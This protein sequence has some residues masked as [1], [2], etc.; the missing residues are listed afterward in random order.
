MS[1]ARHIP[2]LD[3]LRGVAVAGVML[4]HFIGGIQPQT[5]IERGVAKVA[6][7]GVWGVDLFFVLSGFLITGILFDAKG[8]KGYF[9]N[10]YARRTL[11]IFPLYYAILLLLFV[12]LPTSLL[13]R[14]DPALLGA[15]EA[16]AWVWPYLTNVYIA[17]EGSFALPYLSHFWSLAVEEHF[18]LVWPFVVA[19][20][21][22]GAAMR[23][24]VILGLG[25]TCLRIALSASGVNETSI[26]VLTPCRLD[27][28][29]AGAYLALAT[30]SPMG[31]TIGHRASTLM[32]LSGALT[33]ACSAWHAVLG[34]AD[35]FVLPL[36]SLAMALFFGFL[37]FAVCEEHGPALLKRL[38]RAQWLRTLGKYSYGLYVFHGLIAYWMHSRGGLTA[39]FTRMFGSHG[40]AMLLE[41]VVGL[42]ASVLI[43]VLSFEFFERPMLKLKSKFAYA[44][45][46]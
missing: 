21:S 35:A 1:A 25:A 43:S 37:I 30:R 11:R 16:Q 14:V 15:R 27:T 10:F 28:L 19:Y 22:R 26:F 39:T 44:G 46:T 41:V 29:C 13:V 2:E 40:L 31:A 18:Y 20:L 5:T 3:G 6:T 36:R 24:C 9:T 7:Y 4:M 38:L 12:L 17:K 34:T 8:S 32:W 45:S 42:A 23:L 33:F